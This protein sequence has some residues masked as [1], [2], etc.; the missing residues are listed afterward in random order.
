MP[1]RHPSAFGRHPE[2]RSDEGPL[3]DLTRTSPPIH[4][5]TKWL[6]ARLSNVYSLN[7]QAPTISKTESRR[8]FDHDAR[9]T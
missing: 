9:R 7:Q 5:K 2:E 3:F 6:P 8:E 1:P 4:T